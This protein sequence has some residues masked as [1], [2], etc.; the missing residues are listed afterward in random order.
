MIDTSNGKYQ[1]FH[2]RDRE[3]REI[4]FLIVNPY[5]KILAIEQKETSIEKNSRGDLVAIYQQAD[6][7]RKEKSIR[8]QITRNIQSLRQEFAK[9]YKHQSLHIELIGVLS[10]NNYWYQWIRLAC[11]ARSYVSSRKY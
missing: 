10:W 4:D 8:S 11:H 7:K 9:R 6:G 5:G 1:L 2:Y 3:K